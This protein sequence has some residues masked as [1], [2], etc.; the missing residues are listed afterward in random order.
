MLTL[1]IGI[2]VVLVSVTIWY[3]WWIP[4]LNERYGFQHF[5]MGRPL[6]EGFKQIVQNGS[7]TFET[8]TKNALGYAGSA[9]LIIGLISV[10]LKRDRVLTLVFLGGMVAFLPFVVKSGFNFFH[11]KYYVIPFVPVLCV[12]AG[13]GAQLLKR[14]GWRWILAVIFSVFLLE[15]A[16][17]L[18]RDLSVNNDHLLGLSKTL[19]AVSDPQD[20]ILIN[21]GD[22]PTLMYFADRKG[23]LAHPEQLKSVPYLVDLKLKGLKFVVLV[24]SQEGEFEPKLRYPIVHQDETFL[25]YRL[26]VEAAPDL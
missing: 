10:A 17:R 13:Q 1:A 5:F 26:E 19:N 3:F 15:Q 25:I 18:T 21:S 2:S 9:L 7:Q 8:F 4:A 14:P 16:A 20:L 24:K 22:D 23:W 12:L 11:H 6:I